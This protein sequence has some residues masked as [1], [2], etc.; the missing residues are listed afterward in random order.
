MNEKKRVGA[1]KL[2]LATLSVVRTLVFELAKQGLLD[3]TKFIETIKETE[4][5][6]REA[7]DPNN[8]ADALHV[9]SLHLQDSF[10]PSN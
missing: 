10:S 9:V 8:L 3:P 5:A 1:D 2:L 6:H 4:A 7:G